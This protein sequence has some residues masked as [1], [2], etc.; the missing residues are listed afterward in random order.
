MSM[1]RLSRKAWNNVIIVSMLLMILLFNT[2]T[3]ILNPTSQDEAVQLI[4]EESRLLT[5]NIDNIKLERIGSG[6]RN[7]GE[8]MLGQQQINDLLEHWLSAT[9]RPFEDELPASTPVIAI[10]WLAG[11]NGGRVF[12]FYANGMDVV[13]LYEQRLFVIQN[14][15]LDELTLSGSTDA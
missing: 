2:S 12:Q 15:T 3:N 13:V 10:A 6:W 7:V 9:M 11:E 14:M 5:L 1:I 4:P 8:V